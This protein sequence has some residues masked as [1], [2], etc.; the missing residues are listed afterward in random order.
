MLQ[1]RPLL[2][3]TEKRLGPAQLRFSNPGFLGFDGTAY[4]SIYFLG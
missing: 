2:G 4:S 1:K 3:Q